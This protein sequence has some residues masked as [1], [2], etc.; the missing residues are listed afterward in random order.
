M[1]GR[2]NMNQPKKYTSTPLLSA[3]LRCAD[4]ALSTG[5]EGAGQ[6]RTPPLV[7]NNIKP[8][9]RFSSVRLSLLLPFLLLLFL[10]TSTSAT[11]SPVDAAAAMSNAFDNSKGLDREEKN[12]PLDNEKK[13]EVRNL[14]ATR[15]QLRR[16]GGTRFL[17]WQTAGLGCPE[18]TS[19]FTSSDM[20]NLFEVPSDACNAAATTIFGQSLPKAFEHTSN[21][22]KPAGCYIKDWNQPNKKTPTFNPDSD[23]RQKGDKHAHAECSTNNRCVCMQP[24]DVGTFSMFSSK[25]CKQCPRGTASNII[26]T[27]DEC[28]ACVAGMYTNQVKQT[29]CQNC[30][31]GQYT[32]QTGRMS[33]KSC[34]A[35]RYLETNSGNTKASKCKECVKGQSSSDAA[36]SCDPCSAGSYANTEAQTSCEICTSGKY[37]NEDGENICIDCPVGRFNTDS[38]TVTTKHDQ[39]SDC[40]G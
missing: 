9:D 22:N 10:L 19:G 8:I 1:L 31:A 23:H 28:D 16:L 33:C 18:K 37:L 25:M 30:L 40:D 26:G 20:N 29:T 36:S 3:D 6:G 27:H 39:L 14:L 5:G 32:D 21:K 38:G 35:G 17:H 24:C 34:S 2:L 4:F 15:R 11:T 12:I 13:G 7:K